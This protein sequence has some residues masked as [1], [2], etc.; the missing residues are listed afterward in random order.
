MKIELCYGARL[1]R[2]EKDCGRRGTCH[3]ADILLCY[4]DPNELHNVWMVQP[5]TN[6]KNKI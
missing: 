6:T 3:N 1:S 4:A 5:P 2:G